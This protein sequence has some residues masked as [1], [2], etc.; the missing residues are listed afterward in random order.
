MGL[1]QCAKGWRVVSHGL[2]SGTTQPTEPGRRYGP[3]GE[4]RCHC[5]GKEEEGWTAIGISLHTCACVLSEGGAPLLQA[6]GGEKPLALAMEDWA[7]LVQA[8]GGWAPLVW[9]KG[10]RG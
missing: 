9:A 6:T 5:W 2:V 7:L 3:E 10:S 4:T 8:M 1:E